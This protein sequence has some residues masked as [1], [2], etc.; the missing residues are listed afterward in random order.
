VKKSLLML[1]FTTLVMSMQTSSAQS[2]SNWVTIVLTADV[3]RNA[4][5]TWDRIGAMIIATS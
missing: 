2:T 4:D 1:A 5:V 3:A